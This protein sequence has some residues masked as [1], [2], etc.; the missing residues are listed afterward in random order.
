M[1]LRLVNNKTKKWGKKYKPDL[2]MK[3]YVF[4]T[5]MSGSYLLR[6]N[7]LNHC[8]NLFLNP[9]LMKNIY[10]DIRFQNK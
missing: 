4:T 3:E 9:F 1:L 8:K 6:L 2:K 5:M 7:S 10:L